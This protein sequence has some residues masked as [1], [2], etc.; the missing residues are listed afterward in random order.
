MRG[1]PEI[2]HVTHV[3]ALILYVAAA[4][5]LRQLV[6]QPACS[7][8]HQE[9]ARS[10]LSKFDTMFLTRAGNVFSEALS[11]GVK[12]NH[13]PEEL[14]RDGDAHV[15]DSLELHRWN[16]KNWGL[17]AD[18]IMEVALS[19]VS[20]CWSATRLKQQQNDAIIRQRNQ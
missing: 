6:M 3:D 17:A 14:A 4:H 7:I 5:G 2:P 20:Y 19:T 8:Y 13:R 18:E 16:D 12:A 1:Y 11:A 9:H 15:Y 10:P